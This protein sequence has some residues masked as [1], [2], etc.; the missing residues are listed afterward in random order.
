MDA[1]GWITLYTSTREVH[2]QLYNRLHQSDTHRPPPAHR[3][4]PPQHSRLRRAVGQFL[5]ATGTRLVAAHPE[6]WS[7]ARPST[8]PSAPTP[9]ASSPSGEPTASD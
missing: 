8:A 5:I 9:L 6:S 4:Y 2:R 3:A 7:H 1:Y